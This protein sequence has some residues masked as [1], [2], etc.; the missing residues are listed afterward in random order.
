MRLITQTYWTNSEILFQETGGGSNLLSSSFMALQHSTQPTQP[1]SGLSSTNGKSCGIHQAV[2]I[3]HLWNAIFLHLRRSL[4]RQQFQSDYVATVVINSFHACEANSFT[5]DF[6]ALR[7]YW[8]KY[9]HR[10]GDMM[11]SSVHI[12]VYML[13]KCVPSTRKMS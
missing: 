12:Y 2:Y 11:K 7:C 5:M 9:I 4:A 6:D 8:H 13:T 10:G 1:K 3:W